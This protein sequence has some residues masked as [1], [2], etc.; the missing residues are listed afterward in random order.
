MPAQGGSLKSLQARTD[1]AGG[2]GST[3]M[4]AVP[5]T[6][7]LYASPLTVG[8]QQLQV[9]LDAGSTP[10]YIFEG[11]A[12]NGSKSY[13]PGQSNT[14]E[15]VLNHN[16]SYY[17]D[18]GEVVQGTYGRD[19]MTF[20]SV[21]LAEQLFGLINPQRGVSVNKTF[22]HGDPKFLYGIDAIIGVSAAETDAMYNSF[23]R[24]SLQP[25]LAEAVFTVDF[26]YAATGSIEFGAVDTSKFSGPLTYLNL[27]TSLAYTV[28]QKAITFGNHTFPWAAD[29][30]CTFDTGSTSLYLTQEMVTA[31]YQDV[32][33][34]YPVANVD[35]Y[36]VP[37]DSV[38]PNVTIQF[39]ET[40]P[41][42]VSGQDLMLPYPPVQG[43]VGAVAVRSLSAS[44]INVGQ[45]FFYSQFMVFDWGGLRV[46]MAPKTVA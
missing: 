27:T 15:P 40:F 21:A 22:A 18:T 16:F 20:G 2:G 44:I 46:G 35:G 11:T 17:Y 32:P 43:C 28:A 12:P 26:P 5:T 33:G 13:E 34:A 36:V 7:G 30:S 6:H 10:T 23:L 9:V 37:C 4:P 31:Y 3:V 41:V 14:F 8:G 25:L 19:D 39:T 1:L 38:L 29:Q 45:P 24:R 42:T